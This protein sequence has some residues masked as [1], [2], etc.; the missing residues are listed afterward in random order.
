[1]SAEEYPAVTAVVNGPAVYPLVEARLSLPTSREDYK[2]LWA[3]LAR[4][5][6]ADPIQWR[7]VMRLWMAGDLYFLAQVST[8]GNFTDPYTGKPELD[9][10][11][12]FR[13]YRDVQFDSDDVIDTGMRGGHKSTAK[14]FCLPIQDTINNPNCAYGWFSFEV[15]AARKHSARCADEVTRNPIYIRLFPEVF[16]SELDT[17]GKVLR[18]RGAP[19]WSLRDGYTVPG[20]TIATTSPTWGAYTFMNKLP[21]GARLT[22]MIFDDIE[23]ERTVG[24][25]DVVGEALD[26]F[27]SATRTQARAAHLRVNGTFHDP[28]GLLAKIVE[29]PGW[30][31]R[32]YPIVDRSKPAP[33]IPDK[34]PLTGKPVPTEIQE[35]DIEG[36]PLLHH[37]LEV[38][39]IKAQHRATGALSEYYM[40]YMGDIRR[41]EVRKLDRQW[42]Q[43]YEDDPR[44]FAYK[45]ICYI[46]QDPSPGAYD[47]TFTWVWLTMPGGFFYWV[48]AWE[49][50]L[51]PSR[52]LEMT[53]NTVYKWSS[54]CPQVD[55]IRVEQ[56]GPTSYV[57]ETKEYLEKNGV[58]TPVYKIQDFS[59]TKKFDHGKKDRI[60]ARW[61]PPAF[62]GK[63]YFPKR[64]MVEFD[65]DRVEDMVTRF[66]TDEW[67]KFPIPK[68]DNGLDAGSLIFHVDNP[69]ELPKVAFPIA[70]ERRSDVLEYHGVRR[71]TWRSA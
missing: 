60:W 43:W 9:K 62:A 44:E 65:G 57:Q 15:T 68:R 47:P 32:C 13:F 55:Q 53:L 14:A 22:H 52:R 59:R 51:T 69:K 40:H 25:Q 66:M 67:E 28:E 4:L 35:E 1:M 29:I 10:P 37:P 50:C 31:V 49:R 21:T 61:Q 6:D 18:P 33:P 5:A 63:I 34:D 26:S 12:L 7:N 41:G 54:L 3:D 56:Y 46:C 17:E 27:N 16:G 11:F 2:D 20:R 45:G 71:P 58:L 19:R 36:E 70:R 38:A 48:D 30:R 8:I 42:L 39:K 24:D 23:A 64:M